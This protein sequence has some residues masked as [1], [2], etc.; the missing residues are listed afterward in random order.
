[1]RIEL[2]TA[3]A[4]LVVAAPDTHAQSDSYW[5][6]RPIAGIAVP[7][8]SHRTAFGAAAFAGGADL[9]SVTADV[10]VVASFDW[11]SRP[12]R[13]TRSPTTTPTCWSTARAS[14]VSFRSETPAPNGRF[15][16]FAGGGASAVAPSIFGRPRY[17]A[18]H[19]TP[20]MSTRAPVRAPANNLRVE[21]RDHAFCFKR[22]LRPF[23]SETHNEVSVALGL[24]VRF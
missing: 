23:G 9:D 12:R 13:D 10:D 8:G 6:I 1:M 21:L 2:L 11:R 18:R 14:N 3:L 4:V 17:R 19:V 24:G 22:P 20:V 16:S 5:E 7:T 15:T